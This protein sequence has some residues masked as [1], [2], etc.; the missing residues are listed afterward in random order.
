M[1]V[2]RRGVSKDPSPQGE[3]RKPDFGSEGELTAASAGQERVRLSQVVIRRDRDRADRLRCDSRPEG[4]GKPHRGRGADQARPR[5]VARHV[6]LRF[7]DRR[8]DQPHAH[9]AENVDHRS[10]VEGHAGGVPGVLLQCLSRQRRGVRLL[11]VENG[12]PQEIGA[13]ADVSQGAAH[14]QRLGEERLRVREAGLA[15]LETRKREGARVVG[16]AGGRVVARLDVDE[17]HGREDRRVRR[18]ADPDR[19]AV[20]PEDRSRDARA[21]N[22]GA[23]EGQRRQVAHRARNAVEVEARAQARQVDRGEPVE[24]RREVPPV[25]GD[26][27]GED[28]DV[29]ARVAREARRVGPERG[30]VVG[31]RRGSSR[32]GGRARPHE[33]SLGHRRRWQKNHGCK[34]QFSQSLNLSIPL[35]RARIA[36]G[37]LPGSASDSRATRKVCSSAYWPERTACVTMSVKTI[38]V[39]W[40]GNE[41]VSARALA[42]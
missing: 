8:G 36:I 15:R 22:A 28:L 17:V 34:D 21:D 5:R 41:T 16:D 12:A 18:V 38:H 10:H 26:A 7:V 14:Q 42:W 32:H 13:P 4:A 2:G 39:D 23:G 31:D 35:T 1:R 20:P 6:E 3:D 30:P 33:G 40:G 11:L 27:A 29:Q 25:R 37:A 9:L 24:D 19:E